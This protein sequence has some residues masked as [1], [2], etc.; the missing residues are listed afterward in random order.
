MSNLE[1]FEEVDM[2][3][4]GREL[5]KKGHNEKIVKPLVLLF[6]NELTHPFKDPRERRS[7]E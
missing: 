5:V 7:I 4:Q 2:D 3:W 6:K 1:I